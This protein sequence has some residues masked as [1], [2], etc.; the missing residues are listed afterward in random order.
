MA[1]AGRDL[2]RAGGSVLGVIVLGVG[3]C[4]RSSSDSEQSYCFLIPSVVFG[5][6]RA[7]VLWAYGSQGRPGTIKE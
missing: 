3:S 4:A 5:V 1:P 7:D 2:S 6:E